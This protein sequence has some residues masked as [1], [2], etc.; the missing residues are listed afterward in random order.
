[1]ENAIINIA[2][3]NKRKNNFTFRDVLYIKANLSR[4]QTQAKFCRLIT[5]LSV[6]ISFFFA[7]KVRLKNLMDEFCQCKLE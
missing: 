1:M 7:Q 2:V 3:E 5:S 4:S 6:F